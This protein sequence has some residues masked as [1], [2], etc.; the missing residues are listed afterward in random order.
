MSVASRDMLGIEFGRLMCRT[1]GMPFGI[2]QAPSRYTLA[3][4]PTTNALNSYGLKCLL[5]IDDRY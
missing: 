1:L 2:L 5:Y 3:N 4:R